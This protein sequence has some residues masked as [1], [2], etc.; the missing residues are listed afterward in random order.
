[1][2]MILKY[3]KYKSGTIL[4]CSFGYA[5]AGSASAD[6]QSALLSLGFAILF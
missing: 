6:L 4:P 1:M 3:K 5:K 2:E